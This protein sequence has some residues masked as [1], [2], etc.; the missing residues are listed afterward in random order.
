[1]CLTA[2]LTGRA[3]TKVGPNDPVILYGRVTDQRIKG[4]PGI[5]GLSLPQVLINGAVWHL[6]VDS[7]HPGG[8][9]ASKGSVVRRLKWFVSWV[10]SVVR[11]FGSYLP[12]VFGK[13]KGVAS[14]TKGPR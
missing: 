5:I 6:D 2:R 14:S 9:E 13:L 3:E 4:T 10:Q 11:Q 7:S 1:M 8:E 12:W